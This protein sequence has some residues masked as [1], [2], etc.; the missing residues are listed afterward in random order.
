MKTIPTNCMPEVVSDLSYDIKKMIFIFGGSSSYLGDHLRVR[1][2]NCLSV[3]LA[4]STSDERGRLVTAS[5][6]LTKS[7]GAAGGNNYL[8]NGLVKTPRRDTRALGP[9]GMF[10]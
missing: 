10:G 8:E 1:H 9:A 4:S 7:F 3:V 5:P 2:R 6:V